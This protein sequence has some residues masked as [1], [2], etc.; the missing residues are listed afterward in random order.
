MI[1]AD[2]VEETTIPGAGN[3]AAFG[4]GNQSAAAAAP[5][6]TTVGSVAKAA[7]PYMK[8]ASD[9]ATL[10]LIAG[11][12]INAKKAQP[13]LPDA[14]APIEKPPALQSAVMPDQAALRESQDQLSSSGDETLLTGPRGIDP[15]MLNLGRAKLLG[16]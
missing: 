14:P 10:G 11:S 6:P 8:A 12:M 3:N 13:N 7:L 15:S 9:I 5:S 16:Q 1:A 2:G 4:A